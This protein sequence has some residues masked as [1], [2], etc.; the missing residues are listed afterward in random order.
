MQT[1]GK[2]IPSPDD[3]LHLHIVVMHRF[4]H[5]RLRSNG[6]IGRNAGDGEGV[7][8]KRV[9]ERGR[10]GDAEVDALAGT[11][12]KQSGSAEGDGDAEGVR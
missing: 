4:L 10:D 8:L 3:E 6:Y 1:R 12:V 11:P 9:P 7:E 2:P 5:V